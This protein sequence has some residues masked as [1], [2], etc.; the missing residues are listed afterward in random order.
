MSIDGSTS[1]ARWPALVVE[2]RVAPA[3]VAKLRPPLRGDRRRPRSR[4][5]YRRISSRGRARRRGSLLVAA[6]VVLAGATAASLYRR[7]HEPQPLTGLERALALARE[8]EARPAP[9]RR[10]ALG[11]LSDVLDR[12]TDSL[13]DEAEG[14]AWSAPSPTQGALSDRRRGR[15]EGGRPMT[16]IPLATP[17][18]SG[19]PRA[20]ARD[21]HRA[22]RCAGRVR[23]RDG[24]RLAASAHA[25]IVSLPAHSSAIVVLESRRASRPTPTRV[26]VRRSRRSRGAA[27]ATASSSSPTRRTRPCRPGRRP[28]ICGRSSA[29]SR[30]HPRTAA[31]R[32]RSRRTRG[33]GRSARGRRS[34]PASSSRNRSRSTQ[35]E[36]ARRRARQRPRRRSQRR[37][38]A[39]VT[40]TA[41]LQRDRIPLRI[42]GLDPSNERRHA[43]Q[44]LSGGAPIVRAGLV[45]QQ[46]PGC[47]TTRPSRGRCSRWRCSSPS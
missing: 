8:A 12:G 17:E 39:L 18:R 9:D 26:S 23:R 22:R 41:A 36:Q 46:G 11:L 29:T 20:D 28:R 37:L 4:I 43:L 40:I 13:A 25:T 44:E 47:G 45:D 10:R 30:C 2:P 42:V 27:A 34:P 3:D 32:R 7:R 1:D 5:A 35:A 14:L 16:S 19:P 21:P 38:P 15:G 24:R 6:G 31:S 33:R